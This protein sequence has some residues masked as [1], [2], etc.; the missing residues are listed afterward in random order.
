[1]RD[2]LGRAR[3][4]VAAAAALD[5][6]REPVALEE[7]KEVARD[8]RRDAAVADKGIDRDPAPGAEAGAERAIA[9]D[10]LRGLEDV[11]RRDARRK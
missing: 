5:P 7:L 6:M 1:M 11:G 9:P 4:R 10:R 8:R 3:R 2:I